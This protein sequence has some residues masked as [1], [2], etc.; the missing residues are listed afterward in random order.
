MINSAQLHVFL[1]FILNNF[2]WV[3]AAD[4]ILLQPVLSWTSSFV[5]PIALMP[6]LT[7]SLHLCLG[8]PLLLLPGGT[9][10]R[11]FLLT[12]SWSHL[13]TCLNYFSLAAQFRVFHASVNAA[14]VSHQHCHFP[15][16][17]SHDHRSQCRFI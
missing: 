12:Y 17:A 7:Q 1:L 16:F 5:V 6:Q 9:I 4:T 2:C 10:S 14:T 8:L 13:F 3:A 15:V 11:I